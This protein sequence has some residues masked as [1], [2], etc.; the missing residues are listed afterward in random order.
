MTSD[1][2]KHALSISNKEILL[3]YLHKDISYVFNNGFISTIIF[4]FLW[5]LVGLSEL[6]EKQAND[7]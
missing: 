7:L 3:D 6:V 5:A 2:L 1:N 4:F